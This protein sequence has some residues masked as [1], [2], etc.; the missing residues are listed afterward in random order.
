MATIPCCVCGEMHHTSV[1]SMTP[2]G[3]ACDSCWQKQKAQFRVAAPIA[4]GMGQS[5]RTAHL[6]EVVTCSACK[7]RYTDECIPG[8]VAG[9]DG[10]WFCADGERA[11]QGK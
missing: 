3:L 1:M 4:G 5:A 2:D 8:D 6:V 9:E 7:H 10:N 11:E